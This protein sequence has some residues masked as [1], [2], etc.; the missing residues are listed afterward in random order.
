MNRGCTAESASVFFSGELAYIAIINA[1]S[2]GRA[3]SYPEPGFRA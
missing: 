3:P 2:K 1:R